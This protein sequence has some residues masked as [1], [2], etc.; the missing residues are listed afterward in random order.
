MVLDLIQIEIKILLSLA[1]VKP[2]PS[3]K[4]PA[5][6]PKP[7]A[8]KPNEA[9]VQKEI[10][11]VQDKVAKIAKLQQGSREGLKQLNKVKA[12]LKSKND[13]LFMFN[14]YPGKLFYL[15]FD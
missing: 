13:F 11:K 5:N 15:N 10:K 8:T 6:Q 9:K 12:E 1:A 7:N 14:K 2:A 3:S 4:P